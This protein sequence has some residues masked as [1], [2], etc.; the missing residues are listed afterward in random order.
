VQ[1]KER[2]DARGEGLGDDRAA[3]VVQEAIEHYTVE[4]DDATHLVDDRLA[5][6]LSRL[7]LLD[8]A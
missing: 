1:T 2:T 6:G 5:E 8:V 4:A 7:G 3:A